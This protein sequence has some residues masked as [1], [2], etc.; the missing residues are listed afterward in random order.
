MYQNALTVFVM[1]IVTTPASANL[2]KPVVA[3][4]D[5]KNDARL[6]TRFIED[7]R[8]ILSAELARTGLFEIAPNSDIQNALRAKQAESYEDCYDESCQI[9]I[10]K[11][12]AANK[13]LAT[14]VKKAGTRC[15]IIANLYD[16][17]RSTSEGGASVRSGCGEDELVDSIYDVV[18]QLS[19]KKGTR[20]RAAGFAKNLP[21]VDIPEVEQL[22]TALIQL[23]LSKIDIDFLERWQTYTRDYEKSAT[24]DR[25]HLSANE[26]IR[27]WQTFLKKRL[28]R[29]PGDLKKAYKELRQQAQARTRKWRNVVR[30]ER[31]RERRWQQ[32]TKRFKVDEQKL[33]RYLQLEDRIVSPQQ[34]EAY[35]REFE[36]A[37]RPYKKELR[38]RAL[39]TLTISINDETGKQRNIPFSLNGKQYTTPTRLKLVSKNYSITGPLIHKKLFLAKGQEFRLSSQVSKL[40]LNTKILKN[41]YGGA[42][43]KQGETYIFQSAAPFS[44]AMRNILAPMISE[45][46]NRTQFWLR[47]RRRNILIPKSQTR[48]KSVRAR[49]KYNNDKRSKSA[50]RRSSH[51]RIS[52]A[53]ARKR[54]AASRYIEINDFT[55]KPSQKFPKRLG[56]LGV[57]VQGTEI[58]EGRTESEINRILFSKPLK[59]TKKESWKHLYTGMLWGPIIAGALGALGAV[60][61][62]ARDFWQE[63]LLIGAAG[64]FT[65]GAYVGFVSDLGTRYYHV[66]IKENIR[67]NQE[68]EKARQSLKIRFTALPDKD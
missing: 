66:P 30:A 60:I 5:I 15:S 22:S 44:K 65:F 46:L 32:A 58:F 45:N 6:K 21:S 3:V 52:V 59:E 54:N 26:K 1:A 41:T 18:W 63:G 42:W 55:S 11:E 50:G 7:L 8:D 17:R 9:E 49:S 16:L 56:R 27:A 36:V 39:A 51:T 23:D 37:Y 67:K 53:A 4:F 24:V 10:G 34:K 20:L 48:K 68:D 33:Q 19:G 25:S 64:G 57:T 13:T 38:R 43:S 29:V 28:S 2:D 31:E 61:F 35:R 62:D 14:A 12:I 40:K 47:E